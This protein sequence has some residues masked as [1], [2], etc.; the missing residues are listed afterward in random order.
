MRRLFGRLAVVGARTVLG[1][2][3]L[4]KLSRQALL[5]LVLTWLDDGNVASFPPYL[6][7][8][9]ENGPD[10]DEALPYPAGETIEEV[11]QVYEDLRVREPHALHPFGPVGLHILGG[12]P[13]LSPQRG[14]GGMESHCAS[15]PWQTSAT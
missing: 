1:T 4:G 9:E 8:D 7:T 11:R 10:D 14:R 15:W 2:K 3:S 13:Q 5:D 6:Q 12:L